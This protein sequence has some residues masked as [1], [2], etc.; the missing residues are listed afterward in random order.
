MWAAITGVDRYRTWWPWLR[1][2]EGSEFEPGARWRCVVS[3]RLPYRLRI[4]VRLTEVVP[5]EWAR[6]EITGDLDGWGHLT[7]HDDDRRDGGCVVR[8]ASDLQ[9]RRTALHLVDRY[10]PPVSRW[11]HD[12]LLTTGARQFRRHALEE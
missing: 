7:I 12:H 3:L 4:E 11:G 9:P 1:T 6:A 5:R 10:V 8:L 2:F